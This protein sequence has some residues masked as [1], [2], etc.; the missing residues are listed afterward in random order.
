ME[1]EA[2]RN[3]EAEHVHVQVESRRREEGKERGGI[4]TF[5]LSSPTASGAGA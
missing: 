4:H 5:A 3:K 2:V 1:G